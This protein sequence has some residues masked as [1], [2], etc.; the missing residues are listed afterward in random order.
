ME[1]G[2]QVLR[3]VMGAD[4]DAESSTPSL[5]L[6]CSL[7]AAAPACAAALPLPWYTHVHTP[8]LRAPVT[9]GSRPGNG[10]VKNQ[11]GER[12]AGPPCDRRA[13]HW[14]S[15]SAA[16]RA[17]SV[18]PD[19]HS[20]QTGGADRREVSPHRH[21]DQR[22]PARRHPAH[23]RA[24]AVQLGITQP[25]HLE[26]LPARP[27]LRRIRR[28]PCGRADARQP[29]LVS[30]DGGRRSPGRATLQPASSRIR[31]HSRR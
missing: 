23:L 10:C 21:A 28:D 20:V 19:R 5:R 27:F 26:H 2:R 30:G 31:C 16:A 8:S 13:T 11:P 12:F 7:C 4:N 6:P 17:P 18:S 24:D 9:R 15:S 3:L 1:A 29:E 25:A 22:L 14:Q